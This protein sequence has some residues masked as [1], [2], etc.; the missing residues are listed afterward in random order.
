MEPSW[1]GERPVNPV[2]SRLPGSVHIPPLEGRL[3]YPVLWLADP[4]FGGMLTDYTLVRLLLSSR[5]DL[6]TSSVSRLVRPP[7]SVVAAFVSPWCGRSRRFSYRSP[8]VPYGYLDGV[9]L[10]VST[11]A[12]FSFSLYVRLARVCVVVSPGA[13]L[14]PGSS[15]YTWWYLQ[16]LC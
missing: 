8:V 2:M 1:K 9:Y 4:G 7:G 11:G 16:A 3:K 15:V 12:V 14:S 10:L 6:A 5:D 13:K